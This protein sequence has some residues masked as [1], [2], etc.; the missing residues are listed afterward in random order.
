MASLSSD[1]HDF[2][3][4]ADTLQSATASSN[5]PALASSILQKS[6]KG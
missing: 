6:F 5:E 1:S 2:A 3:G 4:E